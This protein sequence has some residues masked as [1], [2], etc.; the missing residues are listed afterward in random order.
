MVFSL[1]LFSV[2]RK[3]LIYCMLSKNFLKELYLSLKD[4]KSIQGIVNDELYLLLTMLESMKM[5]SLVEM[6]D[7]V[8][9]N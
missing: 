5:I 8:T 3:S 6:M 7:D 9:Y 1:V 4:I 2:D